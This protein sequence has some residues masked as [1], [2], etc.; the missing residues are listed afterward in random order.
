M[1]IWPKILEIWAEVSNQPNIVCQCLWSI[2]PRFAN[3]RARLMQ[4]GF[5]LMYLF[6]VCYAVHTPLPPPLVTDDAPDSSLAPPKPRS[7]GGG[8]GAPSGPS[9]PSRPTPARPPGSSNHSRPAP[10]PSP[11]SRPTA[12]KPNIPRS[13][14]SGA[15]M[16][17]FSLG[18]CDG[19][20]RFK[21]MQFQWLL[22]FNAHLDN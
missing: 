2:G 19:H 8:G 7:Y 12:D 10:P 15:I 4:A 13:E 14:F 5:L 20:T 16:I 21:A 3:F 6:P 1:S 22:L 17:F 11:T 18:D 9:R